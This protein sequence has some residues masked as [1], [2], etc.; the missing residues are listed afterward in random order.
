M[1]GMICG[2]TCAVF[3]AQA[4]PAGAQIKKEASSPLGIGYTSVAAA[5]AALRAKEASFSRMTKVG[6]SQKMLMVQTGHSHRP[7]IRLT[8]PSGGGKSLRK[9]E[10]FL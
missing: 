7:I 10:V 4:A 6:R 8:R 9:T 5:L 1:K 3:L 2:V